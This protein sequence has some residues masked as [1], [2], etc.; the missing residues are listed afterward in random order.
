M[1]SSWRYSARA[2][3]EE[4]NMSQKD[5]ILAFMQEHGSITHRQA[6]DYIGCM[7]CA[8]RIN[9]LRNEGH[10]IETES[11]EVKNRHGDK[12]HIAKY[13]LKKVV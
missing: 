9:E 1:K 6:E 12:V 7:R 8:S 11:V 3:Y 5:D 10:K 2:I 4:V 13:V